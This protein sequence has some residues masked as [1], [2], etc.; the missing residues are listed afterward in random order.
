M[1]FFTD[2]VKLYFAGIYHFY[3]PMMVLLA[4]LGTIIGILVGSIPGLTSTM[5]LAVF[6]P[7]TFGADPAKAIVFLIGIYQGSVY[8]GSISAVLV[9]IPGT[10]SAIATGFEGYPMALRG[11]A[12]RAIGFATVGSTMGGLFGIAVLCF[13]ALTLARIALG[14]SAEEYV[15]LVLLGLSIIAYISPGSL[16][17]GMVAGVIGLLLGTVGQDPTTAYPRFTF[18]M[19]G[20]F[21]GVELIPAL[22]GFFG[23][24]EV[25]TQI[26]KRLSLN[27]IQNF[28]NILPRFA[29]LKKLWAT[30]IRSSLIGVFVGAVPAAGGAIAAMMAYGVEKRV[31][32][33]PEKFGTGTPNGI[34][35]PESANNASVGGAFIP[36]LTLGIPGDPMTAVLIGALMIHGLP[37]GP[38]LFK[39]HADFVSSIFIGNTLSLILILILGLA[40]ARFFAKVITT[41]P[42]ILMPIILIFC[43]IGSY[44]IR[45][46]LFDIGI[47]LFCGL[48]GYL[49]NKV[50]IPVAPLT[51]GLVLG[52]MLE[53]NFRRVM[54][55]SE[56]KYT[57]LFTRP[58]S[59]SILIFTVLFLF[60]PNIRSWI[61]KRWRKRTAAN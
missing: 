15:A 53:E 6:T 36:M 40:F 11:E 30:I 59:L 51:L 5:G 54:I 56:G 45:N 34:V 33:Q 44:A 52:P 4:L 31:S 58:I 22:I 20:L 42:Y 37:I 39:A 21:S 16:L 60:Y 38:V 26:E 25:L 29:E 50:D 19:V 41:P 14:F 46:S 35:A 24:T 18:G 61:G 1:D 55:L 10:P 43:M 7:L 32:K 13:S 27:V 23:V 28:K 3:D 48:L 47:T 2:A 12:G 49:L 8:G 57:T 17:R 9:N